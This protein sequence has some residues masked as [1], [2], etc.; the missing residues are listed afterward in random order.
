MEVVTLLKAAKSDMERRMMKVETMEVGS[1][2][3]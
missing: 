3:D 1:R 2:D